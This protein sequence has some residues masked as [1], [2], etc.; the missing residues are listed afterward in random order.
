MRAAPARGS[1]GQRLR[2]PPAL[3]SRGHQGPSP[4]SFNHSVLKR[5][6]LSAPPPSRPPPHHILNYLLTLTK[7]ISSLP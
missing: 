1:L 5:T 4:R 3:F 7:H 2:T 6:R